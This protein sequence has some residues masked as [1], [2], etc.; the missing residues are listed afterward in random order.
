MYKTWHIDKQFS[1]WYYVNHISCKLKKKTFLFGRL[2]LVGFDYWKNCKLSMFDLLSCISI[3]STKCRNF[4]YPLPLKN[5]GTYPQPRQ[6]QISYHPID[7]L[8]EYWFSN[9]NTLHM[10]WNFNINKHCVLFPE[11][12]WM[13]WLYHLLY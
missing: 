6:I 12:F 4:K 11:K 3:F 7:F 9:C 2:G 10:L 8:R 13:T 1:L 5:P